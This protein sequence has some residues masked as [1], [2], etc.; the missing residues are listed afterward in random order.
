MDF[1]LSNRGQDYLDRLTDF[2]ES[3]GYAAEP[4]YSEWRRDRGY[5]NHDLPPVVEDLKK[6]ARARG[7]WNLF[8]PDV[9]GRCSRALSG[10]PSA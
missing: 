6:V 9:S 8:L 5:G 1:E 2:M 4:I 7:L 3:D 10:R